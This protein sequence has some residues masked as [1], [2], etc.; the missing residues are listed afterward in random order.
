ML[1][2]EKDPGAKEVIHAVFRTFHT[3]KGLAGFL[4]FN[5]I[6]D[7]AHDVES[8]LDLARKD[9]IQITPKIVDVVLESADYLKNE[10]NRVEQQRPA[11]RRRSRRQRRPAHQ[12]C[13]PF[14]AR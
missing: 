12:D 10:L 8:L 1:V 5:A 3:I 7:L 9:T 4:A 13:G 11:P 2:L 14:K 6:V